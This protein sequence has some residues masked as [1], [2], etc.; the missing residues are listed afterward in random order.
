MAAVWKMNLPPSEKLV[1]QAYA[2]HA[3]RYGCSIFAS[4]R[5]IARKTGLSERW[6]QL[7]TRRLEDLGVL[8]ADGRG[9]RGTR[10]WRI[11][12][13]W[14]ARVEAPAGAMVEH[15]AR[16]PHEGPEQAP[17]FQRSEAGSGV[18]SSPPQGEVGLTPG[19]RSETPQ[20]EAPLTPGVRSKTPQGEAT[21]TQGVNPNSPEPSLTIIEPPTRGGLSRADIEK[22]NTQVIGMIATPAE[23]AYANRDKVPESYRDYADTFNELTGLE[24]TGR[25]I[26]DW[27]AT[28]SVWRSEGIQPAHVRKA[29]AESRGAFNVTRPGSLTSTAAAAKASATVS[30][31][32]REASGWTANS[33]AEFQVKLERS[34]RVQAEG[35]RSR[36]MAFEDPEAMRPSI[37]DIP[38]LLGAELEEPSSKVARRAVGEKIRGLVH[39]LGAH[40]E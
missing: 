24:P 10:R 7:L 33:I 30:S 36:G 8:V 27:L 3:D 39:R 29:F 22:A 20:G 38:R 25:V 19:V 2:D 6:V 34:R 17:A 16:Q 23:A 1:L 13:D 9:P 40:A 5:S 18:N 32:R 14:Q 4:V 11:I 28:F 15:G 31:L 37:A 12:M 21:L 35:Y 26:S